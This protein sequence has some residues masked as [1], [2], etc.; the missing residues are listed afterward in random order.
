MGELI[1]ESLL[2]KS[3]GTNEKEDSGVEEGGNR[4]LKNLLSEGS[5]SRDWVNLASRKKT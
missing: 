1:L 5:D 3:V 2:G 4:S